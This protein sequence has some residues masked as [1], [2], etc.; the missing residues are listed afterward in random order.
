MFSG[1]VSH[2]NILKHLQSDLNEKQKLICKLQFVHVSH[3]TSFVTEQR[4]MEDC[5]TIV[6]LISCGLDI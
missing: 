1:I 4:K 2:K 5:S 6:V 3:E